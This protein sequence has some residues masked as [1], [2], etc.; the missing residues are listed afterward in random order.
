MS[1]IKIKICGL[2]RPE[3]IAFVNA[4]KPDYI[5]FIFADGRRRTVTPRQAADLKADLDPGIR[6][7]GVFLDQSLSWI[8]ETARTSGIDLIQLHG[9]ESNTFVQEIQ[10]KTGLP[11][12][13]AFSVA[14]SADI[15]TACHSSADYILLDHQIPG[16]GQSFDWS[17][18]QH[19]SR[20]YFLA[21]GLAPSNLSEAL[22]LQPFAVDVS[23]GVETNGC[24]DL[25]KIKEFAALV[26]GE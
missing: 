21:G 9:H 24:K 12:I 19:I 10:Q 23:S 26:R 4:V 15:E 22:K 18:L 5:G 17:L 8:E 25:Q 1:D 6:S 20:P 14:C 2:R 3:D 13:R 16:S 11:V 7:V